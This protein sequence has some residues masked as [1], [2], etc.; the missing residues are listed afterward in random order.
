M[1]VWR[2]ATHAKEHYVNNSAMTV[3]ETEG[4]AAP[5]RVGGRTR[6]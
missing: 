2:N 4:S 5:Q 6:E 3:E 1:H